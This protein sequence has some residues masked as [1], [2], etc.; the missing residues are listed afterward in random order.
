MIRN[1][2]WLL[3]KSGARR[4]SSGGEGLWKGSSRRSLQ[5]QGLG[6]RHSC[7]KKQ[8]FQCRTSRMSMVCLKI[9][10]FFEARGLV[11]SVHRPEQVGNKVEGGAGNDLLAPLASLGEMTLP[12]RDGDSAKHFPAPV[13]R[14]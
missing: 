7:L 4:K 6:G 11:G 13:R 10:S 12:P 9:S 3:S 5:L 14:L 8:E 2:W 1:P